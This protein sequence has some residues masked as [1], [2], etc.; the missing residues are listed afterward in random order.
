MGGTGSGRRGIRVRIQPNCGV[1]RAIPRDHPT[2]R[3]QGPV[4]ASQVRDLHD[5]PELFRSGIENRG[6]HRGHRVVHPDVDAAPL[7]LD[8]IGRFLDLV[9]VRHVGRDRQRAAAKARDLAP[10][11]IEAV[12]SSR[13]QSHVRARERERTRRR[14]THAR[15]GTGDDHGLVEKTAH[16]SRY[17]RTI[18]RSTRYPTEGADTRTK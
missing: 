13:D 9:V 14:S 10:G 4:H 5:A 3:A 7:S 2:K 6:E 16:S 18:F 17:R 12:L 15:G 11:R 1:F 8:T